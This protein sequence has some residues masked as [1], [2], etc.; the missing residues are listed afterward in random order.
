MRRILLTTLLLASTAQAQ[1]TVAQNVAPKPASSATTAANAVVKAELPAD[2]GKDAEF[3]RRGFITT[4]KD[5]VIRDAKGNPTWNLNGYD[6]ARGAAPATVNPSLWRHM[7]ILKDHGLYKLNEGIWQIRGFDVS[8][9][10]LIAGKTGWIII[11]PLTRKESAAAGLKLANEQLG[12]R[13]VVAVIYTHSHSDHFGGAFGVTNREDVDAGKVA[14]IAPEHFT[15]EAVSEN[16]MAGPAMGRRAAYQFGIGQKPGPQGSI[17]SGIG[18]GIAGGESGLIE[19]SD[20]VLKT[21]DTRMI[22]GVTLE[23][24]MVPETE[25][26]AEL[27]VMLPERNTLVIGELATCSQHNILTPRGALVRNALRWSGYL[28]EAIR[29]YA[30]R[31]DVVASSHCWPHFGKDEVR[32]FLS[33]QRD[34]YKFLHDQTIRLMNKGETAP[35]IAEA[36]KPPKSLSDEWYTRGYY[37]TYSHNSKAIYQRYLGWYDAN[38]ANL[39]QHVPTERGK[40]YVAAIGGGKKILTLARAAMAKG[41]YRWS[42]E[43]LNQLVFAE[44]ANAAAKQL[45]A[46]SFEQQGYQAESAIWRNMFL[47]GAF[48]L[49]N[50]ALSADVNQTGNLIN[51]VPTEMLLQTLGT[52]IDPAKLGSL[53]TTIA[54][55]VTDRKEDALLTVGNGTLFS[56]MAIKDSTAAI[57]LSGPRPVLLGML[58]AGMP[59]AK[60]EAAGLKIEGDRAALAALLAA[61][62]A[63]PPFFNIVTP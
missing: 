44:P 45:L 39:H 19:P 8:N 28:G 17:G 42:S 30:D 49:R 24:Q 61:I 62:E 58:L 2:S 18:R 33:V 22:D 57:R 6:F 40:R 9:M 23:F 54:V 12:D 55:N 4:L 34:N 16:V 56:E 15:Q 53:R 60:A 11:D 36:I 46:D 50:G 43:L 52:R 37:G 21:G 3:S 32:H 27:N 25:A 7:S 1:N 31:S 51:G 13:P 35:E 47:S 5:P 14:I 41:D 29:L 10:T 20:L 59:L 26:P 48:E 38:P 63:P